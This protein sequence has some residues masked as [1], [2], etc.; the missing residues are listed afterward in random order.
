MFNVLRQVSVIGVMAVGMT[1]VILTA[2]IDLS[3]RVDSRVHRHG[4]RSGRP[5][6]PQPAGGERPGGIRC[7]GP[8]SRR[9]L[10][11]CCSGCSRERWSDT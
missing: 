5:R 1:F 8:R 11:G 4:G 9:W 2:G 7:C 3:C 6:L 10:S